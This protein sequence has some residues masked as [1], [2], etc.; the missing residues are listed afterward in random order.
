ME[1]ERYRSLVCYL[2]LE[3]YQIAHLVT[4][5]VNGIVGTQ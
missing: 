4:E 5:I 2:T 1:L 3:N